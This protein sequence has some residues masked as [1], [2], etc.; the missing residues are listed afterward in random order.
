MSAAMTG[1]DLGQAMRCVQHMTSDASPVLSL[2]TVL[3]DSLASV[4]HE[5]G[6]DTKAAC[7]RGKSY[8]DVLCG[9]KNMATDKEEV[10]MVL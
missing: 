1:R 6:T 5:E 2:L 8:G 9:L 4:R 3:T 7:N 10:R